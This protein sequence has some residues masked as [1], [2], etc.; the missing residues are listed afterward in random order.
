M[1][2]VLTYSYYNIFK[3]E[4]MGKKA[5]CRRQNSSCLQHG[6]GVET[7]GSD[8]E[9]Q[10]ALTSSQGRTNTLG[11]MLLQHVCSD[12]WKSF[13][14]VFVSMTELFNHYISHKFRLIWFY[15]TCYMQGQNSIVE[16]KIFTKIS[17]YTWSNLLL[18]HVTAN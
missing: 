9:T 6:Q 3:K 8:S 17:Q 15:A 7:N 4:Q 12:K 14:K 1:T 11:G 10:N 2:V 13:L 16:T 18:R 5:T